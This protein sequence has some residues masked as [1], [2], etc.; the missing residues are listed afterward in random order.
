MDVPTCVPLLDPDF[1]RVLAICALIGALWC[2]IDLVRAL[3]SHPDED[4]RPGPD[5]RRK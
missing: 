5:Q 2:F 3:D 1:A 4:S